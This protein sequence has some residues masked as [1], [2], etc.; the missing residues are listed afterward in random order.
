MRREPVRLRLFLAA[1][2]RLD[3]ARDHAEVDTH[4]SSRLRKKGILAPKP[5]QNGGCS[6]VESIGYEH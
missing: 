1:A 6:N 5:A 3:L 2:W 4:A